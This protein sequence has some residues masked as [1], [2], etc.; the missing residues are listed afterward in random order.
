MYKNQLYTYTPPT[1]FQKE[2]LRKI[3]ALIIASTRIKY[4][5][6]LSTKEVKKLYTENYKTLMKENE[7]DTNKCKYFISVDWNN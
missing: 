6:I 2:K 3:I 4:L 5:G 7:K 1:N